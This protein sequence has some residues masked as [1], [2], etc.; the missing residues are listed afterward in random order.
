MRKVSL[1]LLGAVFGAATATV[2][3]NTRLISAVVAAPSETY[4]SLNLFGDVFEK[5]RSDYVERPNDQK[6]I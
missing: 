5:V 6:L 2:A 4:L 1:V 3:T